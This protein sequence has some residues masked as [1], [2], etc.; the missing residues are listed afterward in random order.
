MKTS[1]PL[2][3]ALLF[4]LITTS[5]VEAIHAKSACN[6]TVAEC[7]KGEEE[8]LM[9]SD[10]V[11]RLLQSVRPEIYNALPRKSACATNRGGRY[12]NNCFTLVNS[13]VPRTCMSS[14]YRC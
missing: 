1:S 7:E 14:Y 10:T 3:L 8:W 2:F 11:R 12:T 4:L 13:R 6:G 5:L 9:E